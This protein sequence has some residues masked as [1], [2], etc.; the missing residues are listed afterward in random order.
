[1]ARHGSGAQLTALHERWSVVLPSLLKLF[2]A[3]VQ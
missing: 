2:E 3:G 1:M